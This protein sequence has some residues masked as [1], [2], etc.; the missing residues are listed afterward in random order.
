MESENP[1]KVK[2]VGN[3]AETV[4]AAI[5]SAVLLVSLAIMFS[6]A[7]KKPT[8]PEV[9]ECTEALLWFNNDTIAIVGNTGLSVYINDTLACITCPSGTEIRLNGSAVRMVATDGRRSSYYTIK[10]DEKRRRYYI[11]EAKPNTDVCFIDVSN[12]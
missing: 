10:F 2:G 7:V 8:Y 12:T 3:L 11:A 9:V 1:G 4:S 5:L 6:L